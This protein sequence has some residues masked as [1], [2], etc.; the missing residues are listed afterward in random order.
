MQFERKCRI[1]HVRSEQKQILALSL[2]LALSVRFK[3]YAPALE[4]NKWSKLN[5]LK[6]WLNV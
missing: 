5:P 6:I 4:N 2:P 1:I 3:T